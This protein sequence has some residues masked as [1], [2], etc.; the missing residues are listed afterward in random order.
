MKPLAL[1]FEPRQRTERDAA[2]VHLQA[3]PQLQLAGDAVGIVQAVFD[4]DLQ[5]VQA[6]LLAR[7]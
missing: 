3:Q 4:L 1:A 5:R 2:D 7:R 6:A